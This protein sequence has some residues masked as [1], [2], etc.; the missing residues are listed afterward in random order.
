MAHGHQGPVPEPHPRPLRDVPTLA[1]LW[2]GLHRPAGLWS[3]L[4]QERGLFPRPSS[5][6]WSTFSHPRCGPSPHLTHGPFSGFCSILYPAPGMGHSA[7]LKCG[8]TQ[9]RRGLCQ[10]P[11]QPQ[12]R[13]TWALCPGCRQPSRSHRLASLGLKASFAS[14]VAQRVEETRRTKGRQCGR[15]I[16][17]EDRWECP[18][19]TVLKSRLV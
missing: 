3:S 19:Q 15:G 10:S 12:D 14:V 4:H 11:R 5:G 13:G 2:V 6:G 7:P 18:E 1:W 8:N 17:G 9:D 16:S